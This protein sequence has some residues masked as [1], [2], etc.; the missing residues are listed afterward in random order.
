MSKKEKIILIVCMVLGL[1]IMVVMISVGNKNKIEQRKSEIEEFVNNEEYGEVIDLFYEIEKMEKDFGLTQNECFAVIDYF[2]ALQAYKNNNFEI[3]YEKLKEL[4]PENTW[5]FKKEA[6]KFKNKFL[7]S[8]K[9][10]NIA[11]RLIEEEKRNKEL[12]KFREETNKWREEN[13]SKIGPY[14]GMEESYI[15]N[16]MLGK[17]NENKVEEKDY[18]F[19]TGDYEKIY[20]WKDNKGYEICKAVVT[21]YNDNDYAVVEYVEF[22]GENWEKELLYNGKDDELKE[23]FTI[24]RYKGKLYKDK[25][26]ENNYIENKSDEDMIEEYA[27]EYDVYEYSDANEF[28]YDHKDDFEGY[29]DAE[30][31]Y[32]DAWSFME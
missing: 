12:N 7:N 20:I 4:N 11:K 22:L 25:N 5:I 31:Y 32:E 28:Y 15:N 10:K 13:I 3:T 1:S 19:E 18:T 9:G 6:E 26:L 8:E 21:K 24:G 14:M 29:E 16:T 23:E 30:Q 27:N 2:E 17:Y